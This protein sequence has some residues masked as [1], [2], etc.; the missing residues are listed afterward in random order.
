M[1]RRLARARHRDR[2]LSGEIIEGVFVSDGGESVP[3]EEVRL[4]TPVRPSKIVAVAL[5]WRLHAE[6]MGKPVPSE[7]MFFTKP[8]SA[9][10]GP[11]DAIELPPDS[12]DVQHEGEMGLVIGKRLKDATEDEA[13]NA[14]LGVT[15]VN[16]I[17]A[18]DVQRR[19]NHYTRSKGYDTF[20]PVGPVVVTGL[21]PTDLRV[22][23]RVNGVTKQDGRTCDLVVP[24]YALLSYISRVMTLEPGDV[25]STGTPAGVG[26]IRAGDVVEVEVEGVG[27]LQNPVIAR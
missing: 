19:Q 16:D 12:E 15:C 8:L 27:I 4:L 3:L 23:V 14:I 18:R 20:C 7:T 9:L 25:V 10:I 26:R 17:T 1:K 24:P 2:V 11:G 22:Q 6:E 21:D 5:N 13:R